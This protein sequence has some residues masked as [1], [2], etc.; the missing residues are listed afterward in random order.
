MLATVKAQ[1]TRIKLEEEDN[2]GEKRMKPEELLYRSWT[3]GE[4]RREAAGYSREGKYRAW[5][6]SPKLAER[7][8][9]GQGQPQATWIIPPVRH[10]VPD[11]ARSALQGQTVR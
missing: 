9:P 4:V 10:I 8:R 1:G 2:R 5:R 7:L 3:R 6:I 11:L